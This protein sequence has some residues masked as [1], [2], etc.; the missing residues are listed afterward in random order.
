MSVSLLKGNISSLVMFG[1]GQRQLRAGA[2]SARILDYGSRYA[3][4]VGYIWFSIEV[5]LKN[6]SLEVRNHLWFKWFCILSRIV[7]TI[8]FL[9]FGINQALNI[10]DHNLATHTW[11]RVICYLIGSIIILLLHSLWAEPLLCVVNDFLRLFKRVKA[12]PGC[13]G[14]GFG[15][16][17]ELTLLIFKLICLSNEIPFLLFHLF[18]SFELLLDAYLF[19]TC[20][21]IIHSCFVGFLSVGVL[22]DR[23]NLYVRHELR[24][25]LRS[26]EQLSGENFSRRDI[27]CAEYRLDQCVA[28]YDEI[29]RV[30][31][32]FQKLIDLPLFLMLVILF[33]SMTICSYFVVC[34]DYGNVGLSLLVVK[35]FCDLLL[36]TLS[37]HGAS[38]S[39]RL[40]QRLSLENYYICGNKAWHMRVSSY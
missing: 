35:M 18:G 13:H 30:C 1:G 4:F 5:N 2:V 22:Y 11:I 21:M 29:Q 10:S 15:G 37:V 20:S 27:K 33:M 6:G 17:R 34:I 16:K 24:H 23:V 26:L 8:I 3:C 40:I 36:L 19:I 28:I 7:V 9:Y 12:L 14:I 32:S 38:I 39:S 25:Q 31:N